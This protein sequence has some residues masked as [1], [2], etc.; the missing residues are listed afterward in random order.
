M[1]AEYSRRT[2][3]TRYVTDVGTPRSPSPQRHQPKALSVLRALGAKSFV[4]ACAWL[5]NDPGYNC[6]GS[7]WC[8]ADLQVRRVWL[9]EW[10]RRTVATRYALP[11]HTPRSPS[12]QRTST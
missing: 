2:V 6:A 5:L 9:A 4:T 1:L 10:S 8:R 12:P 3:A 11:V 7:F